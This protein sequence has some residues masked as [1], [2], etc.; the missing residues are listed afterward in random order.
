MSDIQHQTQPITKPQPQ[1]RPNFTY[2]I[3]TVSDCILVGHFTN[4]QLTGD[5]FPRD[6]HTPKG[7]HDSLSDLV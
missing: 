1:K 7:N 2:P 4:Q 3:L 6:S 5:T